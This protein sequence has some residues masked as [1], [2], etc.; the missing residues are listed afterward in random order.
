MEAA[1][2]KKVDYLWSL[3]EELKQEEKIE[4]AAR[5]LGSLRPKK[6]PEKGEGKSKEELLESIAGSWS[7]YG[8][9]AEEIIDFI[10]ESRYTNRKIETLD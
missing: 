5:L 8:K 3:L 9:S 7:D 10:K 1:Y 4:L 6:E 2:F